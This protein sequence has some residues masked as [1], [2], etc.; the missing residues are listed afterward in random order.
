ME[1]ERGL[2]DLERLVDLLLEHLVPLGGEGRRQ[3]RL[4]HGLRGADA[5]VGDHLVVVE[6]ELAA[7]HLTLH[8]FFLVDVKNGDV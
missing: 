4:A 3:V 8:G 2:D 6:G 1:V 7:T 5:R